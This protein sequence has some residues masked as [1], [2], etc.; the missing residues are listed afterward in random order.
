MSEM[1][2]C[3]T[4][5][6]ALV[7]DSYALRM[8]RYIRTIALEIDA[9][10]PKILQSSRVTT[11]EELNKIIEFAEDAGRITEG[12]AIDIMRADLICSA[13]RRQDGELLYPVAEISVTPDAND[14]ERARERTNILGSITGTTTLAAVIGARI[15]ETTRQQAQDKNVQVIIMKKPRV[16]FPNHND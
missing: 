5:L 6:D 3:I 7:E 4:M 10:N 1:E 13:T 15:A 8:D 14:V 11:N 2:N 16:S 12:K 9:R